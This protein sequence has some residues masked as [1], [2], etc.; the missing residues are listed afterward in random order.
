[1]L[2]TSSRTG[3]SKKLQPHPELLAK[4]EEHGCIGVPLPAA[5]NSTLAVCS[6]TLLPQLPQLDISF[7]F[8]ST[9][10]AC[11]RAPYW[12]TATG[13]LTAKQS[14]KC[15]FENS[16]PCIFRKAQKGNESK[17]TLSGLHRYLYCFPYKNMNFVKQEL[18]SVFPNDIVQIHR[19]VAEIQLTLIK[20]LIEGMSEP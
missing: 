20:F 15:S 6:L 4:P 8:S 1:M 10:C 3:I 2:R 17:I 5:A 19:A 9:L 13:A 11:E 18:K 14:G 12:L 7:S 16:R